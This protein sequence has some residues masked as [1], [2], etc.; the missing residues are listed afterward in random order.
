[1]DETKIYEL[2]SVSLDLELAWVRRNWN[3]SPNM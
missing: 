2:D 1:M 3:S